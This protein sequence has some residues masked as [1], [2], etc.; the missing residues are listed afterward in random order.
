M[1]EGMQKIANMYERNQVTS[2]FGTLSDDVISPFK[3]NKAFAAASKLTEAQ[4]I[5]RA[6]W[7][8]LS[9]QKRVAI[10]TTTGVVA[11]GAVLAAALGIVS[12]ASSSNY[13]LP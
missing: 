8:A 10:L 5:A 1:N 12:V 2:A 7:N 3:A 9:W 13:D 6:Q 11:S 4:L